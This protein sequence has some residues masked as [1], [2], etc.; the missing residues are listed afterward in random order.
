MGGNS[1]ADQSTWGNQGRG[2]SYKAATLSTLAQT[3][4]KKLAAKG[5]NGETGYDHSL[6]PQDFPQHEGLSQ[7]GETIIGNSVADQSTWGNQGRGISYK[8]ATLSTLAQKQG[9][10][11]AAKGGNG[12][13]GY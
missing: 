4:G 1:V 13:T 11:L 12:E 6:D 8:A 9:K 7:G 3:Q 10:K 2:I 5:G